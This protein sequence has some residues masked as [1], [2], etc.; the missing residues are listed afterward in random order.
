MTTEDFIKAVRRQASIPVSQITFENSDFIDMAGGEMQTYLLPF[1]DRVNEEFFLADD[2]QTFVAGSKYRIHRRAAGCVLRDVKLVFGGKETS[3]HRVSYDENEK[4]NFGYF[5]R[6]Q[7]VHFVGI[8]TAPE[9]V[10][11]V[12]IMRPNK[13][14]LATS[15]TTIVSKTATTVTLT[16]TPSN[17]ATPSTYDIIRSKEPFDFCEKGY[18][19]AGSIA[20]NVLTFSDGLGTDDFSVG[21]YVAMAGE[22]PV[23]QLPEPAAWLL[24]QQVALRCLEALGDGD[25]MTAAMSTR[26]AMEANV[27][28]LMTQRVKGDPQTIVGA[29]N[30]L[31]R[32]F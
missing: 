3:P 27:K 31:W 23:V 30:P 2:D 22:S 12:Y 1:I 24:A 29:D 15:A 16:S 7:Y 10:R 32:A 20:A 25:G 26:M 17:F 28:Q 18:D 4:R 8:V 14:V 6:G 9:T 11:L 13:L 5:I 19:R 21:D